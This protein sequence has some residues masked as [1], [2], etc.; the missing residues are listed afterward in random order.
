MHLR[1][2]MH[3]HMTLVQ[4]LTHGMLQLHSGEQASTHLRL[5]KTEVSATTFFD[6]IH[7][8]VSLANQLIQR[9][10]ICRELRRTDTA[11]HRKA[12]AV[13]HEGLAHFFQNAPGHCRCALARTVMQIKHKLIATLAAQHIC[14]AQQ[15][16]EFLGDLLKN[17]V[18][19][20]VTKRVIDDFEAIQIQKQNAEGCWVK[21]AA[22]MAVCTW[23]LK[24][25][26]LGK[27][28]NA[29]L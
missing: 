6:A 15:P 3:R 21:R 28:V 9:Q 13:K 20:I 4:S 1:L 8:N 27:P 14:G 23:R 11:L 16:T 26:R 29:S 18:A 10:S 5:I 2:K 22:V 25:R 19:K 17:P 7:G 24:L 12:K